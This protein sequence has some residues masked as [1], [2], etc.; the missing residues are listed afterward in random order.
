VADDLAGLTAPDAQQVYSRL[1]A[2]A[3]M[4]QGMLARYTADSSSPQHHQVRLPVAKQGRDRTYGSRAPSLRME[5]SRR[6]RVVGMLR[7]G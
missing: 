7:R 6:A 3:E 5:Q 4:Y 1:L 2:L